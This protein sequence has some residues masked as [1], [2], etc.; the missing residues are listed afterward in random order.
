MT[1]QIINIGTFDNDPNADNLR[2]GGGK[3]NENFEEL[4]DFA[5]NRGIWRQFGLLP[6]NGPATSEDVANKINTAGIVLPV[7]PTSTP[8]LIEVSKFNGEV[9]YSYIFIFLSGKGSWGEVGTPVNASSFRRIS[10]SRL[11]PE[12]I[13]ND[14]NAIFNNLDPVIAGDFISKANQLVWDFSDSQQQQEDGGIK[15][16]YFT[17]TKDGVLYFALFNGV[18]GIYGGTETPFTEDMFVVTTN[19]DITPEKTK[20][21]EFENDVPYAT[22][23]EVNAKVAQTITDGVTTSAPSQDV[24]FDALALKSDIEYTKTVSVGIGGKYATLENLF[25]TEPVGKTLINLTDKEYNCTDPKFVM[26]EGWILRGQGIGKTKLNFSFTTTINPDTSGL[27]V[28]QTCKIEDLEVVTINN[29]VLGGKSQYATH[30]DYPTYSFKSI[31]T[32]CSFRTKINPVQVDANGFNGLTVGVGTWENQVIE[33]HECILDGKSLGFDKAYTLNLH[34]TY[35]SGTHLLPS[36]VSFYNSLIS[37]GF[38]SVLI[39]DVYSNDVELNQNRIQDLF[40]FIG[41]TIKGGIWL[42]SHSQLGTIDKKN[43]ILFNFSGSSIDEFINIAEVVDTSLSNYSIKSLPVTTDIEYQKNL[44]AATIN[45]GDFVCYVYGNRLPEYHLPPTS[46]INTIIG[47]EKLNA[48]NINNFAGISLVTSTVSNY[49]HLAKGAIAYTSVTSTT[50]NVGDNVTFDKNGV[51]I[52]AWFGGIGV[53]RKKTFDNRLGVEL[54]PMGEKSRDIG[55]YTNRGVFQ[56]IGKAD[57][58]GAPNIRIDDDGYIWGISNGTNSNAG[59]PIEKGRLSFLDFLKG[60]ERFGIDTNGVVRMTTSNASNGKGSLEIATNQVQGIGL[61]ASVAF[62]AN[63]GALVN[64]TQIALGKIA[65]RKSNATAGDADG[66]LAF[67]TSNNNNAAPYLA[68]VGRWLHNGKLLIGSI[69]DSSLAMLQV[70]GEI[71]A[72]PGTLP[73]SVVVNSQLALKADLVAGKVPA[74]QLPSY[75]DDVLEYVNLAAFPATGET[76][77]LYIA[78]D[79]N[80]VYR[81]GGSSYVVTSSSLALGE[82]L[83]TAYRGDRGKIAYDHSQTTGNPH[84]TAI[85]DISGLQA[86]IDAKANNSEIP[87]ILN[88]TE[89]IDF[90]D[91]GSHSYTDISFTFT[92]AVIGDCVDVFAPI[93]LNLPKIYF[94]AWVSATDQVTVRVTNTDTPSVITPA[95]DFKFRIIK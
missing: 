71:S 64:N 26:K 55:S 63:N 91:L 73:G 51:L 69:I 17:Y 77:K 65:G 43:G 20:L 7:S 18:P 61:G 28:R 30:I 75:V 1:R 41:C 32:R 79:T 85:S 36:R 89:N 76:G 24:V 33:F 8:V 5:N 38:T 67:E 35:I 10:I 49:L 52:K 40:E 2:E 14:P 4:Y 39:S 42:R 3:I 50:L 84:G 29:T 25:L 47:V 19:S 44:G 81:W 48:T 87:I 72:S 90:P 58:V 94:T 11:S 56:V 45:T 22:V 16:Y 13:E 80:L 15:S 9:N 59:T 53:I 92:G 6:G 70:N 62:L 46:T 57:G 95:G 54:N 60:I 37:G 93:A 86:I 23:A 88:Q 68:E 12:D 74:S 66:Y 31:I 83:T 82:T 27:H 78:I 21:S 34:N